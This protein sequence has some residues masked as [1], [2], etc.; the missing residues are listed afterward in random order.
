VGVRI[1]HNSARRG[2]QAQG[3]VTLQGWDVADQIAGDASEAADRYAQAA[4]DLALEAKALDALEK[5]FA[6]FDSA[7]AVSADLRTALVSPL[8]AADEKSRALVAVADRIG[9]STLGRNLIGVVAKNGRAAEIPAVARAF[10]ARLAR[11]RGVRMVEIVSARPLDKPQLDAILAGLA[12]SLGD[13]V[14]AITRVDENLIGGFIVRAGSRQFD[15]SLKS[16]LD[17]LKL[18]LKTA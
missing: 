2:R 10:R 1:F 9:L 7:L 8:I 16:K 13:K 11:H 5:D 6:T 4:F 12:K 18:A 3:A 15:A 17:T 14:D